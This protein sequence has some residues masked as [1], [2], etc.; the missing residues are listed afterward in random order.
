VSSAVGAVIAVHAP[1][2]FH[3]SDSGERFSTPA[4]SLLGDAATEERAR[5]ASPIAHVHEGFPPTLL[6]HG[7]QDRMV[8]HS[9]SERMLAALRDVR[10]PADLHLFH[11][12]T[13]GFAALPSVRAA[14]ANE[15]AFFL[16]RTIVDPEKHRAEIEQFS[17]F[18]RRDGAR[19]GAPSP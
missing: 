18:A 11:G 17:V 2:S 3:A 16:D 6:L 5:A 9:A 15:V 4:K 14:I 7:T 10:A 19:P 13:H 1:T 12:H 8:H